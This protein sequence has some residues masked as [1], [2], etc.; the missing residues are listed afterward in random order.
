MSRLAENEQTGSSFMLK[1]AGFIVDKR[2]LIFLIV[3]I[4]LIFSA[5]SRNWVEVENDLVY[6]LPNNSATKEGIALMEQEFTTFGT[7]D[8]MVANI[9]YQEADTLAEEIRQLKGVQEVAFDDTTDHFS[10]GAALFS[11]TFAYDENNEECLSALDRVKDFLSDYDVYV[12]TS[13]GDQTSEIIATEVSKIMVIV[14]IIVV[15]VL[16]F[17]SSTYAEVPVLLLTFVVAAIMNMGTS[18]LLGKISFVSNSVTTVLQLALSLDY[19]VI[20]CNRYK[21]EHETLGIHEAAI[22]ALSKA[23]PEIGAS[24][25]T[26]MGGLIAMMFMQFQLGPDMAINLMKSIIFA[27]LAVFTVMPGLLVLFGPLMDKTKHKNFVPK[28]PFVGKVDY[29]TR[30]VVPPVFVVIVLFSMYYSNRCPYVYGYDTLVTPQ[31]NDVQIA[32]NMIKEYFTKSNLVALVVPAGDYDKEQQLLNKLDTY[33]EVDHTQG[34]SNVEAL[35]GY[36]LTDKLTPRKFSE[37]ANL[38]YETAELVFSAYAIDQEAYEKLIAGPSTYEVPLIDLFLFLGE[39]VSNSYVT[40]DEETTDMLLS[41]Y[42]QMSNAKLQLQS[43][44]YSRML[45]YLTLPEGGEETYAF[46]DTIRSLVHSYYPEGTTYVVGNSTNQMEF[47]DSFERDNI[48]VSVLSILIVL[49][50]LLFTFKSAG[51]PILLI[52]VIQ[53]SIWLNFSFPAITG[54]GVFF[55]SY[56]V[57]SSIQMGA[58]IDYAIVVA[59]RYTEIK[60]QM[61]HKQAIIETLN[62]AFPTIVTSGTILASAG[63]LIGQ[64]T[65]EAAIVGIGQALGRGT[66]LSLFLVMFILPQV[67]LV[68]SSIVDKTSFSMKTNLIA[69]QHKVSGRVAIDGNVRGEIHGNVTGFFRGIVDGDVNLRLTTGTLESLDDAQQKGGD[70]HE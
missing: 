61:S 10:R 52:V 15:T 67:L 24:S 37:L 29:V 45:V 50:V 4:T 66:I 51:M 25:L 48:V 7:A 23:I 14:A 65:S 20:L 34:L 46:I 17:T 60:N 21:E 53:G 31:L 30:F 12:S 59:S 43:E 35:D 54:S 55:M 57:V 9:S 22:V 19:A 39:Q 58:N 42:E 16:I 8:Y 27:L 47:R 11:V 36:M 28:I 63:I 3:V 38:D 68:G 2:N 18:F 33:E 62:F 64:M 32:D 69:L 49:V 1:L 70:D 56:L 5:F 6:Y 26:T 13:L 41:A 40:L 44:D